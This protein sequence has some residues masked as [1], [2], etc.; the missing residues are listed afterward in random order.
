MNDWGIHPGRSL[1]GLG[2]EMT[3]MHQIQMPSR[4]NTLQKL[5]REYLLPFRLVECALSL[6]DPLSQGSLDHSE[7]RFAVWFY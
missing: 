1:S 7:C 2:E 4:V 6:N 3:G 5:D